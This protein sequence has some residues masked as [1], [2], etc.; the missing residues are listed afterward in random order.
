MPASPLDLARVTTLTFDCYGT[1][2]DWE[3]S[4]IEVLRPLLAR[5]G[6]TQSDDEIVAAF[7]DI[8]V[9]LSE[10]PYRSYRTVLTNVVEGFGQH[11]RFSVGDAERDAFA[12]SVTSWRPFP[13]TPPKGHN[14]CGKVTAAP[15]LLVRRYDQRDED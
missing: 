9:P 5:H 14:V 11:F 15:S 6:V 10:P 1:L 12:A 3:A 4:A 8:E 2:I 7:Q 13:A